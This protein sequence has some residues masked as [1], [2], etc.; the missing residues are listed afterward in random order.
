M[1]AGHVDTK[2]VYEPRLDGKALGHNHAA[3]E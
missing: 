1:S 2:C 3:E